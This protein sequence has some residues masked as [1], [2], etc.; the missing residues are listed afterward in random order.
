VSELTPWQPP[1]LETARL[2]LRP[3]TPDD[4]GSIFAHASNPNVTR[5]TLWD[6]HRTLDDTLRF[7]SEYVPMRTAEGVPDPL[8]ICL[9]EEPG[10]VVGCL[11]CFWNTKANHCLEFGYWIG[12]PFW[13][14]GL[15]A[16]AARALIDYAFRTYPVERMQAHYMA[17][18]APSGRVLLKLGLT[19]EGTLR[20]A[21]FHRGRF[22]DVHIY[23]LLRDEWARAAGGV[24]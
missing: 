21:L 13:G 20:S 9:K 15:V 23:S 3:L 8:G 1:R 22:R 16:E 4:A 5:Y 10:R 6:H 17:G 2:L 11:G 12:E 7:L 14:R 18:N 24:S 19:H